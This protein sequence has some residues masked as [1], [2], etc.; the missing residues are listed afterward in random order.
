M[1][2]IE[3]RL[4]RLEQSLKPRTDNKPEI[5]SLSKADYQVLNDETANDKHS[6]VLKRNQLTTWPLP[7][8]VK[9]YLDVDLS[10]V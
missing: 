7:N 3:N 5:I 9:V 8:T 2:N 1:K 4:S 10:R 6:D